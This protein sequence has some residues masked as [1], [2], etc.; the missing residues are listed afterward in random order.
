MVGVAAG[1]A[2]SGKTVFCGTF[3][4]FVTQRVCD[5][6]AMSVAICRADVKLIGV[7][8][9]LISGRN[10]ASHQAVLD[11]A[12]M[13]AMPEMAVFVPGDAG[14]TRAI[15]QYVMEHPG[16]VYMRVPRGKTPVIMD[17]DTCRFE[18][19]KATRV[20][21]G[22]DVTII[23]CGIM[24][25]RSLQAAKAL[26]GEGISVRVINMS[27]IKPL[28]R[29]AI[30]DAARETGCIVTA[31]NHSILGGLGGAVAEVV[32][33]GCPVP[34]VRVGICD[35]FGQDGDVE[36]LAEKYGIA[37]THIVQGAREALR[38]KTS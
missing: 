37:T 31:E 21:D 35:R 3:A 26:A 20:R 8:A 27:S 10:G 22:N 16:P 15:M 6:V 28:D 25:P 36:W 13:R 34:V 1:L 5:Q 11:L 7:E 19:G 24:L 33:S 9:G 2:L 32:T 23:T 4:S 18:P 38:C 12:M 14:Q 29:E 17:S 30:L